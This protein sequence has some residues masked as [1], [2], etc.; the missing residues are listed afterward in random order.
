MP[1]SSWVGIV[2]AVILVMSASGGDADAGQ[3]GASGP[4]STLVTR[5]VTGGQ[6]NQYGTGP[7]LSADGR[8]LAYFSWATNLVRGDHD[9]W[10]DVFLWRRTTRTT[11]LVSVRGATSAG[12]QLNQSSYYA[13]VSPDGQFVIFNSDA[14]NLV[15]GAGYGALYIRNRRTGVTHLLSRSSTGAVANGWTGSASI[16]AD[17]RYVVFQSDATNLVGRDTN[18]KTDIFVRDRSTGAVRRVNLTR[19]GGQANHWSRWPM[20]SADGRDIVFTSVASNLVPG[21]T[22]NRADVFVCDRRTGRIQRASVSSTGTQ[23]TDRSRFG[24]ISGD[25]RYVAFQSGAPNLVAGDT[26]NKGDI[27]VR[28]RQTGTTTLVSRSTSGAAANGSSENVAISTD[29]RYVV[30]DSVASNLVAGDTN[31]AG[32]IF[33]RNLTSGRTIRVSITTSGAQANGRS[34]GRDIGGAAITAHGHWIAFP[35]NASNLVPGD[36]SNRQTDIFLRGPLP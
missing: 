33:R 20:I 21:D 29:G 23:T 18:G 1:G 8:Y 14:T 24:V 17:D 13:A 10:S 19:S 15:P 30:F 9:G 26:N 6:E 34:G 27:F 25:G 28:D 11:R 36:P 5:S 35:S 4:A 32:D 22:N 3:A 31:D 7:S 16:A 2:T 12:H